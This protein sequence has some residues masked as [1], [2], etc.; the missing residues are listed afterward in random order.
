MPLQRARPKTKVI[1]RHE[2]GELSGLKGFIGNIFDYK[3]FRTFQNQKL[4]QIIVMF[5]DNH[6]KII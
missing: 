3:Q 5:V 4:K 1:T 2:D 6:M